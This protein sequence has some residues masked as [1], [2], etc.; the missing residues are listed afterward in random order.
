M[1]KNSGLEVEAGLEVAK[2]CQLASRPRQAA[3][4]R[5]APK[6]VEAAL[7]CRLHS[8]GGCKILLSVGSIRVEVA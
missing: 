1:Q 3:A 4:A 2:E 6:A 7:E 8:S 5:L